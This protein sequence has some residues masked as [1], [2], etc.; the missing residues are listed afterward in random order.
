[1]VVE[2]FSGRRS[3]GLKAYGGSGVGGVLSFVVYVVVLLISVEELG[4][5]K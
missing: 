3:W 5:C 2:V 1:M 4:C